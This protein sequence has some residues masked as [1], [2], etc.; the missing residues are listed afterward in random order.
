MLYFVKKILIDW[1]DSRCQ[2]KMGYEAGRIMEYIFF[3]PSRIRDRRRDGI[4]VV[5]AGGVAGVPPSDP[6]YLHL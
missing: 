5:E 2:R 1:V 3:N 4:S 6:S